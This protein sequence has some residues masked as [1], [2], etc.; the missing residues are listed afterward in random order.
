MLAVRKNTR[1]VIFEMLQSIHLR[2][3]Q[4][5]FAFAPVLAT[6]VYFSRL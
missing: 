2:I 4:T 1:G 6:G 5:R 3:I